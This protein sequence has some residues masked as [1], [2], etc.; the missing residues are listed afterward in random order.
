MRTSIFKRLV[1]GPVQ[2]LAS[3]WPAMGKLRVHDERDKAV[4]AYL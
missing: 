1:A 2:V 3:T 4:K